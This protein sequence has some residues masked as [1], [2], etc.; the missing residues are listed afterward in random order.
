MSGAPSRMSAAVRAS[1][2]QTAGS[3]RRRRVCLG[4]RAGDAARR[5]PVPPRQRHALDAVGERLLEAV[6]VGPVP[7]QEEALGRVVRAVP[8]RDAV[9]AGVLEEAAVVAARVGADLLDLRERVAQRAHLVLGQ[10]R[11]VLTVNEIVA[12]QARRVCEIDTTGFH[13]ALLGR[14]RAQAAWSARS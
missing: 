3:A 11:R 14:G 6:E 4:E 5:R 8:V 12:L 7:G 13:R 10:Q 1:R 2:N 9:H